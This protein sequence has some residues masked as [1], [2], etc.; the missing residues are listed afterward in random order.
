MNFMDA[1][2]ALI[3]GKY[4]TRSYWQNIAYLIL[5]PKVNSIWLIEGQLSKHWSPLIADLQA[6][7]WQIME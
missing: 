2:Q 5:L 6:D 3:A 7:D 4:V 1:L